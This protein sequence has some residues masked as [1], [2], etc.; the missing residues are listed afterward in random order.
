MPT[1]KKDGRDFT[2][3][4]E[5][6]QKFSTSGAADHVA[7]A[8]DLALARAYAEK[9]WTGLLAAMLLVPAWQWP[10]APRLNDVPT[11]IWP[12]Y[13][14][15]V[16]YAPQ[17][18][19]APGQADAY[20]AHYLR[21]V[22][23]LCRL[24]ERNRGSS[25][26][27]AILDLYCKHGS[28]ASLH[29]STDSLRQHLEIRARILSLDAGLTRQEEPMMLP[30]A[31]RRLR[32]GFVSTDFGA[33]APTNSTIPLF[34]ELD[35]ERFEVL[36]FARQETGAIIE[37]HARNHAAEFHF[38]A[39]DLDSQMFV[40][41][42]AALDVVVFE[43]NSTDNRSEVE[44]LALHRLAPLQI[45]NN[46]SPTTSGLP[47]IDLFVS[48]ALTESTEA[49]EHFSERLGLLPGPAHV[50]DYEA[51]RQ[52]PTTNWTRAAL[53]LS[54]DWTVF[55]SAASYPKITPEMQEAWVKLLAAVPGSRLLLHPFHPNAASDDLIKRFCAGF[56]CALAA[57]GVSDSRL[58]VSTLD[59]QSRADVRALLE[60]G[61]IY[62]DTYP[63]SDVNS[64]AG[65]LATGMPAVVWEGRTFRSRA[66]AG[67]MRS[68]RLEGL[69]AENA[70][71]YHEIVLRLANDRN[72]CASLRERI[73]EKMSLPPLFLDTLAASDSFGTLVERAYDELFQFGREAFRS[74]RAPL[75]ADPV[76]AP[77]AALDSAVSLFS[78]GWLS[79]AA[80]EARRILAVHPSHTGAR[81]LLAAALLRQGRGDRALTY[82]QAAIRHSGNSAPLWHDLAVALHLNGQTRESLQALQTCLRIDPSRADFRQMLDEW[83][84]ETGNT[85]IGPISA[86][87][88]PYSDAMPEFGPLVDTTTVAGEIS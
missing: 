84:A 58:L 62:L 81:H 12:V 27:R 45:V 20:A 80:D 24:A 14:A 61:D 16:F 25:A 17:G 52:E 11:W 79:E 33:R 88:Q 9:G 37:M 34:E 28:C 68:L 32:V 74:E 63:F 2:A 5:M 56:D 77:A 19:S 60:V 64:L 66:S 36:L 59:L 87:F 3:A 35:A 22:A 48:G 73:K 26:V 1:S 49:P 43:I 71:S 82:L 76:P 46:A 23:E 40:L 57:H 42:E 38:L 69:V 51:D 70:A 7:T 47:E 15:Y 78:S 10:E 85:E 8:D 39:A 50:F 41:R 86:A 18:F 72:G 65:I 29:L 75:V 54:D 44:R 67:L 55:V 53:G 6:L 13:A 21:R 30:R 4:L 31:G 83:T